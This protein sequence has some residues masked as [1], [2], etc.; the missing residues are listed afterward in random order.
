MR[1]LVILHELA[2]HLAPGD[3]HG[4]AF[5]ARFVHLVGELIGDEAAFLL[6]SALLDAGVALTAGS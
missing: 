5:V 2:H 6:R 3:A 4:A 1:E